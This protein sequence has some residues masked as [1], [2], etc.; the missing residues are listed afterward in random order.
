MTRIARWT[1]RTALLASLV[2]G[3]AAAFAAPATA[4]EPVPSGVRSRT[5]QTRAPATTSRPTCS[6]AV[7]K[8]R[9]KALPIDWKVM[10]AAI[11]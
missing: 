3:L 9:P 1:R 10:S 6:I 2:S 7:V 11:P 4:A 8:P 5:E